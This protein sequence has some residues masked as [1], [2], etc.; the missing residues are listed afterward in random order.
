LVRVYVSLSA[1][2]GCGQ[3]HVVDVDWRAQLL[4]DPVDALVKVGVS[5]KGAVV[6]LAVNCAADTACR[7]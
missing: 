5:G 1:R 2:A 4:I 3:A 6:G 7:I